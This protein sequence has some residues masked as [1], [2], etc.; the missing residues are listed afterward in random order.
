MYFTYTKTPIG[1]L[2]IVFDSSLSVKKI[3][4]WE[5]SKDMNIPDMG[6]EFIEQ[7]NLYFKG[8]LKS[9]SYPINLENTSDFVKKVIELVNQIPFGC[10]TTYSWIAKAFDTSPRA[11]GKALKQNPLPIVIPCHR[12][13]KSDG[14]VGGYSLGV[15]AKKWLIE[16]ER[17]IL[18]SS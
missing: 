13:V 9:F 12:V 14:R 8:K 7:L 10:I 18:C 5:S 2:E 1:I 16:H 6:A 15:K 17:K 4:K 11:V 3:S